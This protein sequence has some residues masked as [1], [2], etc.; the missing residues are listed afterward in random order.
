MM[1]DLVHIHDW[2]DTG[3]KR[4]HVEG[5]EEFGFKYGTPVVTYVRCATCGQNGYRKPPSPV[6]Y[7][8]RL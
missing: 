1:M 4:K 5:S 7:T 6:I 3:V 8:W 2:R